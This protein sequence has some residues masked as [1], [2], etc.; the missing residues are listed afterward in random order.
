MSQGTTDT[1]VDLN[2][3]TSST[4]LSANARPPTSQPTCW[5]ASTT[6][7]P[8]GSCC[9]AYVRWSAPLNPRVARPRTRRSPWRSPTRAS[10][11]SVCPQASLESFAPEFRQ[12]MAARA[13][14]LGDVGDSSPDRW[15]PPLGTPDVHVA[16]A[17]L[18][19][20]AERLQA[21]LEGARRTYQQHGRRRG[22]LASGL[23]PAA[24]RAHVVRVQGRDRPAGHRRQRHPGHQPAGGAHQGRRVH[25][26]LPRRN[27]RPA[28]HARRRKYS[29]GTGPISRFESCT[30]GWPPTVSTCGPTPRTGDE[31][32]RLGAKMVGRWQSGAP[33]A[34]C[35]DHDDPELGADPK[36]NNRFLYADDLGGFRC[37]AGAHARRANPRDA[38]GPRRER[39]RPTPSHDPARHELRAAATRRGAGGRRSSIGASCSS[40]PAPTWTASSSS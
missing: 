5:R 17:I 12:G 23:L 26:R 16:I 14:E 2:S 18:S 40:S 6:G 11:R 15:E 39:Q 29:A 3:T 24:D 9:D 31:E 37:P 32:K 33:L 13:A 21:S 34:L 1:A 4:G 27:R 10:R 7:R 30:P 35:P 38:L 20:D 28:A 22:D 25:P 36:R 19:P 8:A